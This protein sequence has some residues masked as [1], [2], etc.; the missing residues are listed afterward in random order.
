M[1]RASQS[2]SRWKARHSAVVL[3]GVA[4]NLAF[5]LPLL[6]LPRWVLGLFDIPAGPSTIWPQFAGG[7]LILLSVFYLPMT[8]DLDRYRIF[9]WLAVFPSRSFGVAFFLIALL[10]GE[11]GGFFVAVLI[12]GVIAIAALFCLIRIVALEQAVAEGRAQP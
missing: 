6:F 2:I 5:A 3:F 8:W 1:I 10:Q 9:A 12:D 4:L 7:L 11:P